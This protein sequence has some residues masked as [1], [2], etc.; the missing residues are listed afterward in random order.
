MIMSA[1]MRLTILKIVR[2][3]RMMILLTELVFLRETLFTL[4]CS[5]LAATCAEDRPVRFMD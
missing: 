5:I 3:L 4:P 1:K 2:V